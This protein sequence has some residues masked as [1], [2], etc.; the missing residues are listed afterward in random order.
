VIASIIKTTLALTV[1]VLSLTLGLRSRN[2]CDVTWLTAQKWDKG[3][4]SRW[5]YS[6]MVHKWRLALTVNY[7]AVDPKTDFEK[8]E[9]KR[10]FPDERRVRRLRMDPAVYAKDLNLDQFSL[11]KMGTDEKNP[12]STRHF[13][14]YQ[15]FILFPLWYVTILSGFFTAYYSMGHIRQ[16]RRWKNGWCMNCGYDLR[17]S[18]NRCPECGK[19]FIKKAASEDPGKKDTSGKEA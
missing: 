7:Q 18:T 9:W 19:D 4:M 13:W 8:T 17:A 5:Q 11:L 3:M 1:L 2:L 10:S 15:K 6:V 16:F 14:T 12:D